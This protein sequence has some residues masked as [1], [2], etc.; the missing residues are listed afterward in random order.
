ML[1]FHLGHLADQAESR[2]RISSET[3]SPFVDPPGL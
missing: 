2:H 3:T 1:E